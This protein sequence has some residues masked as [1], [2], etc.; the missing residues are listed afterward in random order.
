GVAAGLGEVEVS[1]LTQ[2]AIAHDLTLFSRVASTSAGGELVACEIVLFANSPAAV[3][4]LRIGHG[5]LSDAIDL[6]GV[7]SCLRSAGLE[8]GCLLGAVEHAGL[9]G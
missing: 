2:A 4:G 8:F 9:A 7:L 6:R 1:T 5:T 3:P